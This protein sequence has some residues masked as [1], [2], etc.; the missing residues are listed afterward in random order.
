M[1]TS[2]DQR[3]FCQRHSENTTMKLLPASLI[4]IAVLS[5]NAT[6]DEPKPNALPV[7]NII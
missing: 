6:A 2:G 1:R 4:A 3:I 7:R 5:L